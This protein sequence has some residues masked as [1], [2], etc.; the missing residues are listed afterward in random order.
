MMRHDATYLIALVSF[1]DERCA[2]GLYCGV[3]LSVFSLTRRALLGTR[4]KGKD[5]ELII[6]TSKVNILK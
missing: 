4:I 5:K 3:I 6:Y 2:A 1:D